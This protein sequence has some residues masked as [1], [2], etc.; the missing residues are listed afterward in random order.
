MINN[1][2]FYDTL[3]MFYKNLEIGPIAEEKSGA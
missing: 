2:M 1:Y 3:F